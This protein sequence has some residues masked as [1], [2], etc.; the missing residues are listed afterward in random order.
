MPLVKNALTRYL[1]INECLTNPRKRYWTI[2]EIMEKAEK[3]DIIVSKRTFEMDFAA[4]RYDERLNY[5]APILYCKRN[6]GFYYSDPDYSIEKLPLSDNDI[7]TFGLIVESFQRFRGA[8]VLDQLE[9]MFDKLGK[10]AGQLKEKK[11]KLPYSPIVF[12]RIPYCKGIEHFD[13]LYQAILRQKPVTIRYRK[14]EHLTGKEHTFHPYLLK[15]Y[16]FRWYLLGYSEN[17]RGKLIL[18]LDRVEDVTS[19]KVSFKPYKGADIERYFYHTI[20][21]T[22]NNNPVQEVMLWF[23]PSQGNYVKT[24][25]L[26][27]TQEIVSDTP[28]GMTVRLQLIPNYELLQTLLAFGP[29]VKVLEPLSLKDDLKEML[30]KSLRLYEQS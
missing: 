22:I 16:K 24:Q 26:H 25:H 29:E 23:S 4:M 9:G 30:A 28:Q 27:A 19:A 3:R 10:V 13:K 15:E 5:H 17:R 20:G 1:L 11:T 7:E 8:Q 18:A 2:E 6:K 12:E 14:F 21:V